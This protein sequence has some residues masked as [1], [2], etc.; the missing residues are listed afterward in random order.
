MNLKRSDSIH[1]DFFRQNQIEMSSDRTLGVVF[2]AFFLVLAF[3]PWLRGHPARPWAA[4][5]AGVF[6]TA[7]LAVPRVLRPLNILWTRLGIILH[8][9]TNPIVMGLL[10]YTMVAPIGVFMRLLRHDALQL[11]WDRNA[12]SYWIERT[13]LGPKPESM[14]EQF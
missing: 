13:R 4:A 5:A 1:E 8:E 10:F 9:T 2:A 7:S 14:K 6:L 3:A 12:S 11:R